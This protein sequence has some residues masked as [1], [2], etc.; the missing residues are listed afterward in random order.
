VLGCVLTNAGNLKCH[1]EG[2]GERVPPY[3]TAEHVCITHYV[4]QAMKRLED[5][6]AQC[7]EGNPVDMST[8]EVLRAHADFAVQTLAGNDEKN[9]CHKE[10]LLQFLLGLA[11]LQQYLSHHVLLVGQTR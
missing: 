6:A 7:R 8:L 2:C 4:D 10:R 3:L 5:A 11:N 9:P 1:A